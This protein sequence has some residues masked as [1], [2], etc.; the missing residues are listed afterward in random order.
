METREEKVWVVEPE[1]S[2]TQH[3]QETTTQKTHLTIHDEDTG[4]TEGRAKGEW[5]LEVWGAAFSFDV[6]V[7]LVRSV[8][9]SI[10]AQ[11]V[12]LLRCWLPI[13]AAPFR[14]CRFALAQILLS[15][16]WSRPRW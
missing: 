3:A 5:M 14:P 7:F 13:F 12:C 1:V 10:C 15:P 16:D 11:C 2:A 4:G 6:F 8:C 9:F